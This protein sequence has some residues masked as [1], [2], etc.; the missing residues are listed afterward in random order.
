MDLIP[1][2]TSNEPTTVGLCAQ[3][4]FQAFSG[5]VNSLTGLSKTKVSLIT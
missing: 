3:G 5:I 4:I 1:D 2:Y